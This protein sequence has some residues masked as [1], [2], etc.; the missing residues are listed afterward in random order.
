MKRHMKLLTLSVLPLLCLAGCGEQGT[1]PDVIF[2]GDT[3]IQ[4]AFGG[5][6]VEWGAYE[7]T[8]KLVDGA[9]DRITAHMERL[10]AARIR[11]MVSYDWFCTNFNNHGTLDHND[12]TWSYNFENKY[13]ANTLDILEYCQTHDVDVAFGAWNII[14]NF[15]KGEEEDEWQMFKEVTSDIRWAKITGDIL[16]Y[17]VN[18]KGFTCIKWFVNSNEPNYSGAK[19]KDKNYYNTYEIWEQGVKN[20]RAK[21]DELGLQN[22]GIVGGDTTGIAGCKEYL[23]NIS[24][25]IPD[26]VGDYGAH[27]Y[28]TNYAIASGTMSE[29][30]KELYAQIQANDPGLGTVRQANIWEAGL[31]DGKNNALDIQTTITMPSYAYRMADY[32]IQALQCNINGITYWDFDDAMHFMYFDT[33]MTPKEWGMFSSL[34]SHDSNMQE[35][36]PWYHSSCLLTNLFKKRNMIYDGTNNEQFFRSIATMNHERTQGGFVAVNAGVDPVTKTFRFNEKISGDKLYIYVFNATSYRLGED[37]YI[38]PNYVIDGSLNSDYRFTL[39]PATV[40][41]VSN[42]RLQL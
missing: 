17:F 15:S 26:K 7:D 3:L 24:K 10:G 34:A 38:I 1:T 4:K 6:G 37:G 36:R 23:I 18:K 22:I 25:R 31:Y 32:T 30:I 27:L 42:T 9:W 13:M 20:V 40:L 11:L 28:L 12:D 35:L 14:A 33:G 21:L 5:L 2:S 29:Q 41:F 8:D 16:D 39:D 19:G